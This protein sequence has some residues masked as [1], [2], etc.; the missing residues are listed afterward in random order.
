M[1]HFLRN[2]SI[3]SFFNQ[4]M[5]SLYIPYG[6]PSCT[7]HTTD[8]KFLIFTLCDF[9]GLNRC[10]SRTKKELLSPR[11]N[12]NVQGAVYYQCSKV[13]YENHLAIQALSEDYQLY[14]SLKILLQYYKYKDTALTHSN[15]TTVLHSS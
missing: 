7:V 3:R 2:F 9:C 15:L 12:L 6:G 8:L 14:L 11:P 1:A 4:Q 13:E 5:S 10:F